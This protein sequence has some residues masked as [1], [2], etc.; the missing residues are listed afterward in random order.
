[1]VLSTPSWWEWILFALWLA[2]LVYLPFEVR[3]TWRDRHKPL[4]RGLMGPSTIPLTDI[5][6]DTVRDIA[7]RHGERVPAVKELRETYPGLSLMD[8]AQLVDRHRGM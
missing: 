2:I 7:A 8:A 5:D 6:D 1:R 4:N 3:T